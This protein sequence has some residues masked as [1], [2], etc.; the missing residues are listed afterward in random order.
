MRPVLGS[1]GA[2]FLGGALGFLAGAAYHRGRDS[3]FP[4]GY[5]IGISAG[6]IVGP[7]VF[8][9]LRSRWKRDGAR[10]AR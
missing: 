2:S 4:V 6:M 5:L 1:I 3:I 7:L 9:W 8:L 10:K